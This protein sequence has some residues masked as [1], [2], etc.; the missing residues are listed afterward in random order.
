MVNKP[1]TVLRRCGRPI[2]TMFDLL[3][4]QENDVTAAIGWT[5]C[6][7][8]VLR[9]MLIHSLT[10]QHQSDHCAIDLQKCDDDR[11]FTDIEITSKDFHIIIEAKLGWN[12]PSLS[13]LKRYSSRPKKPTRSMFVVVSACTESYF[14]RK[15]LPDVIRKHDVRHLSYSELRS[16]VRCSY[17]SERGFGKMALGQLGSYLETF[18]ETGRSFSNLVYVVALASGVPSFSTYSWI[19]MVEKANCYFHPAG[20]HGWPASPPNYLGFRY[21]GRLQSIHHVD[22]YSVAE[23]GLDMH[24]EIPQISASEWD[25]DP[26]VTKGAHLLYHLGKP[27]V[28]AKVVKSGNIRAGRRW[29]A[30]DLLLTS[31]SITEAVT[32]TKQRNID[33][34][35]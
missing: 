11:G 22:G 26:Y 15:L 31:N 9:D 25:R 21:N 3:G 19:Q 10:G 16:R 23:G 24:R 34:N 4:N 13:Q 33:S 17:A 8:S 1:N 7:S 28:P 6:S 18:M 14:S 5:L 2:R 12:M 29:A 35:S 30:I 32:R 20:V 27:I